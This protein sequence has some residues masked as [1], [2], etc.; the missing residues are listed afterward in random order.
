ML[1]R[2]WPGWRQALMLV[3][4][5]TVVGWHRAG[6]KL[7]WQRLSRHH[8]AADRRCVSKGFDNGKG[9]S[10]EPILGDYESFW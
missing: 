9:C 7:Y 5:E 3:Q 1:R 10:K 6:F 8:S 2:F 4:P